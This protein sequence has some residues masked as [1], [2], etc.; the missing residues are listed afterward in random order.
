MK[1]ESINV[2]IIKNLKSGDLKSLES[3]YQFYKD[4]I[5]YFALSYVKNK[6]DAEEV[7]Q[8]T[9]VI[10]ANNIQDLQKPKAFHSWI[11]KIA[12]H[13]SLAIFKERK[14]YSSL[15]S[16]EDYDIEDVAIEPEDPMAILD[17]SEIESAVRIELEKL[18]EKF[19]SVAYLKYFGDFTVQEIASILDI[20]SGTVKT[21]L[22]RV[23][24]TLQPPLQQ[25]G[26]SPIK[27][28]SVS[29]GPIFF[30]IFEK[31]I[32]NDAMANETT[33]RIFE[34]IQSMIASNTGGILA[35]STS[36][37]V[38][39]TKILQ[40]V[41]VLA[42]GGAGAYSAYSLMNPENS[43]VNQISYYSQLTNANVE[44]EIK[45]N[46]TVTE[47]DVHINN[48]GKNVQFNIE[49]KALYFEAENNGTYEIDV[50]GEKQ[51]V[52]IDNIDK[53]NPVLSNVE[54]KNEKLRFQIEKEG[55]DIDYEKSYFA[56]EKGTK[57]TL[58]KSGQ[59]SGSFT[60]IISVYLYDTLGNYGKYEFELPRV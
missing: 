11:H 57:Y 24:E 44:V 16:N 46:Q 28:L 17:R 14:R 42:L 19:M 15:T 34:N 1:R 29:A 49:D 8:N 7:L 36:S 43:I 37:A 18:P 54:Y 13:E 4:S 20:P 6:Q 35:V 50:N 59:M 60:G 55:A 51:A 22:N 10:V 58:P 38:A 48:N 40:I 32:Q 39:T 41:G 56:D 30:P 2:Q 23:R 9:F 26:Y 21:R 12:Y 52:Q 3:I 53:Q 47:E 33:N 31:L 45:L 25:K 5:Y 27:Y